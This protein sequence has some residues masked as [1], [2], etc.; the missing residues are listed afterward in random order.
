MW[1]SFY[2]KKKHHGYFYS[3]VNHFP[4]LTKDLLKIFFYLFFLN[5]EKYIK[6]FYRFLGLYNSMIGNKSKFRV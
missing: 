3:L 4:S 6:H 2:F 5:K 1:S